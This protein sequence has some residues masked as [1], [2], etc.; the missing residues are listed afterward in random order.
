MLRR[1]ALEARLDEAFAKRLTLL[2]A[3][4]GF[5]KSTLLGSWAAD[6]E[7]AWYTASAKDA[8]LSWLERGLARALATRLPEAA[9]I[10]EAA[11]EFANAASDAVLHA[12]AFVALL[13]EQLSDALAHDLVLVL[14]D[15]HELSRS[16]ASSRLVESLTRQAPPSLHVVLASRSAPPFPIERL[17]A[18]GEVLE[19]SSADLALTVAEIERLVHA[20]V[21]ESEAQL[22]AELHELT[23]GWPALVRLALEALAGAPV[24]D[25]ARALDALRGPE[26]RV[27]MYL[28]EEV[29]AGEPPVVRDLIRTVA[30]L[31]SFTPELCAALGID[32]AADTI[33]DLEHRGLFVERHAGG[34]ALHSLARD[35][36][37][38]AWPLSSSE[39]LAVRRRA[40]SW[41]AC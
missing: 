6:V 18:Q 36:A 5:G 3:D 33:R 17:R 13:C 23:G 7:C 24:A 2:V 28:A 34:Y 41:L 20:S 11:N 10:V 35:F 15:A 31:E 29:F 39:T 4:A 19:F 22:A 14:D 16:E 9:A 1:V 37:L 21:G 27:F 12:D 38:R 25:R 8:S 30:V 40:A 26:S 32:A